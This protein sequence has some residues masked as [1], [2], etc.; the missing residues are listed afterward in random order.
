[1]KVTSVQLS[2]T[3]LFSKVALNYAIMLL[4][5][6][7]LQKI[8]VKFAARFKGKISGTIQLKARN[9]SIC[10]IAVKTCADKMI[11][12]SGWEEFVSKHDI[13]KG[14]FLIFRYNGDS[15]FKVG[16]FDPSGCEKALSCVSI[17]NPR[18]AETVESSYEHHSRRSLDNTMEKSSS[19]TPAEEP[20]DVS[21]HCLIVIFY[22]YVQ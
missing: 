8:P 17:G 21:Q 13:G 10:E 4:Q 1:M 15:Q 22:S 9:G 20:G 16:I 5:S 2:W 19:S 7:Y 12:Q 14:D 6:Y 3:D 18:P 11:L